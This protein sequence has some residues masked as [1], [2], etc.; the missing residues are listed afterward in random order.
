MEWLGNL[1]NYTVMFPE[2][3]YLGSLIFRD[4][5]Y[6]DKPWIY[7]SFGWKTRIYHRGGCSVTVR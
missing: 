5:P 1:V 7:I 2:N 3:E 4:V 6:F